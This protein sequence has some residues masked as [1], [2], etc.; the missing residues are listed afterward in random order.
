MNPITLKE[1]KRIIIHEIEHIDDEN[2]L[3][4]ITKLLDLK[5]TESS[6]E[7]NSFSLSENEW[8]EIEKDDDEYQNGI[9]NSQTW[10][11]VKN[12]VLNTSKRAITY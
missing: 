11:E 3:S 8:K 7:F 12:S 10:E 5:E 4:A 1:K 9:G 2:I 6:K